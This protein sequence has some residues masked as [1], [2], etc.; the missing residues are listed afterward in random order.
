MLIMLEFKF[1]L[2][3]VTNPFFI[4]SHPNDAQVVPE[5]IDNGI[6]RQA[7]LVLLTVQQ[8]FDTP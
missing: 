3:V 1:G 4:G 7:L 2:V 5:Q 8:G 6:L